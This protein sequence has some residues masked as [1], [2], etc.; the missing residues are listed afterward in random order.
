MWEVLLTLAMVKVFEV[1]NVWK[2]D[3]DDFVFCGGAI[4]VLT[5]KVLFNKVEIIL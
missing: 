3:V 5:L 4:V 2:V 1:S